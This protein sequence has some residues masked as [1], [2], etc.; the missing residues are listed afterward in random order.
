MSPQTPATHTCPE[1][2]E[3]FH[4]LTD[5]DLG[6]DEVVLVGRVVFLNHMGAAVFLR[7]GD[8]TTST[9]QLYVRG[10][11]V[12]A[13]RKFKLHDEV[14]ARGTAMR[15]RLG[16]LSLRVEECAPAVKTLTSEH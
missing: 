9:T 10:D 8:R 15:T 5:T 6:K 14:W 16:E 13:A 2:Y 3:Q 1:F 11:A 4:A 12:D 7:V